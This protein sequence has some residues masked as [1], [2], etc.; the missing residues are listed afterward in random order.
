V[1]VYSLTCAKE[2][3]FEGWFASSSA[4]DEQQAGGKLICPICNT[5][6]VSKAI[7]APALSGAVGKQK[8]A[9]A[10]EEL[11]K[12]R[13]FMTGLRKHIEENAENVGPKFPEEARKIH[14]GEVEERP[15][16]GEATIAEA[17]EL[18]E[19]GVDVAPLPPDLDEIAN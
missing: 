2:H 1:I 7:M 3:S 13:Q 19:E 9:P 12:M 18:I 4:F 15:I 17:K 16:Y 5:H 10:P 6:K 11:R 8:S 14:Y